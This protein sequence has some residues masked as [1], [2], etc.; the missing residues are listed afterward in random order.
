[1]TNV[2][3]RFGKCIA[4]GAMY[5]NKISMHDRQKSSTGFDPRNGAAYSEIEIPIAR[6]QRSNWIHEHKTPSL[7]KRR[8]EHGKDAA[9]SLSNTVR[10]RL[11]ENFSSLTVDH[12]RDVVP[13]EIARAIWE[14]V[15]R[16]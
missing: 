10:S 2:R 9:R 12:F 7:F 13:W 4:I 5:I 14:E 11:V 15:V 6:R 1:M 8:P 16:R 3:A